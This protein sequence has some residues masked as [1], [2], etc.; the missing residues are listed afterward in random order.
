MLLQR[1]EMVMRIAEEIEEYIVELGSDGR[2]VR[3]QLEEVLGGIE[4]E[5]RLVLRDYFH[6]DAAWTLADAMAALAELDTEELLDLRMVADVLHLPGGPDDLDANLNPR[7]YRLLSRIPRIP[8][9]VIDHIVDHFGT[10]SKIMRA[11]IDDLDDVEGVGESRARTI[12]DGLSRLAE[13]SI[14]DRYT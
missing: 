4:D 3:L 6:D 10:L 14:L 5:R 8:E 13:A 7:G 11:T 12:K 9:Q 1:T 2:L